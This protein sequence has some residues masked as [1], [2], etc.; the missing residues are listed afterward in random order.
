[1]KTTEIGLDPTTFTPL[2]SETHDWVAGITFLA[3]AFFFAALLFGFAPDPR[4]ARREATLGAANPTDAGLKR[5]PGAMRP[6]T[7]AQIEEE[8][9][10]RLVALYAESA[11]SWWDSGRTYYIVKLSH[12]GT[13]AG[14]VEQKELE[15]EDVS[16]VLQQVEAVGWHLYDIGYVYQPLRERSHALTT[17]NIMT[18]NIVGIYTF[19]REHQGFERLL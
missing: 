17:S 16:G 3:A 7:N 15:G 12:G 1:V 14:L 11:K 2:T 13:V 6:D 5:T 18:G 8:A 10:Q 19:H 4:P 9:R